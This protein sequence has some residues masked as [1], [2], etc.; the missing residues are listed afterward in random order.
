[1]HFLSFALDKPDWRHRGVQD[2]PRNQR[3]QDNQ[4]CCVL[5]YWNLCYHVCFGG[6]LVLLKWLGVLSSGNSLRLVLML[7]STGSVWSCRG[8][9]QPSFRDSCSQEPGPEGC[10]S[11]RTKKLRWARRCYQVRNW[12]HTW[13]TR[14]CKLLLLLWFSIY[15]GSFYYDRTVYDE[16]VANGTII[17]A[18]EVPPPTVPMDY[19][20]ARVR[21]SIITPRWQNSF[22]FPHSIT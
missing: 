12:S 22:Y 18:Q 5:V 19:S 8:L 2:L 13:C 17:P 15:I 9:C 21:T 1:M 7:P 6:L 10:R 4:A 14:V 11:L 3:R 20:W 16:L